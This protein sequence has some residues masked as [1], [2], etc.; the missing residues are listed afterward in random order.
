MTPLRD[1]ERR[2][3]ARLQLRKVAAADARVR[4]PVFHFFEEIFARAAGP[5]R[6]PRGAQLAA[7]AKSGCP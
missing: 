6:A 7:G 3:I 2:P 4:P 5:E 1:A